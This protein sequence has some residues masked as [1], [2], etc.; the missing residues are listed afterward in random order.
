MDFIKL[1][2][3]RIAQ[4][5]VGPSTARGMGPKGTIQKA[6]DFLQSLDLHRFQVKSEKSFQQVLEKATFEL[7]SALPRTA[8]HWGS[9]RKFLNIFLRD[10]VYNRYLC[11]AYHFKHLEPWLELPL[12]SHVAQ[13]LINE[14]EGNQLPRWKT[15]IGLT[16]EQSQKY[17]IFA[18]QVANQLG[19]Y[20]IHL[21][22][23]YYRDERVQ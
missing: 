3:R 7:R 12:D 2:H 17:Q 9:S 21:D 16:R 22:L 15:V 11:D 5:A 23:K 10:L 8:K 18:G 13:G 14:P 1:H 20:R 19:T 6:R 4:L